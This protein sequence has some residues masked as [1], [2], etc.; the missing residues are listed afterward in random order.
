[1]VHVASSEHLWL[2]RWQGQPPRERTVTVDDTPTLGELRR[3][4]DEIANAFKTFLA[5]LEPGDW[6]KTVAYTTL[7]GAASGYPLWQMY[8]QVINHG[9]HHR[10]E[11]ATMLTELGHPPEPLDM[12]FYFRAL[13]DG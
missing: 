13:R 8:L 5:G 7:D 2:L 6:E 10:A 11:A 1:M 9:T 12:I 4:W 3:R